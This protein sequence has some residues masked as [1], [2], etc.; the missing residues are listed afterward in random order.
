MAPSQFEIPDVP[1]QQE[2]LLAN[3]INSIKNKLDVAKQKKLEDENF[4]QLNNLVD[5]NSETLIILKSFGCKITVRALNLVEV[6]CAE[7]Q[8]KGFMHINDGNVEMD[9]NC[10]RIFKLISE[11]ISGGY[12]IDDILSKYETEEFYPYGEIE[13]VTV[14]YRGQEIKASRGTLMNPKGETRSIVFYRG[15]EITPDEQET[16]KEDE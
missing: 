8:L 6:D 13:Q 1:A 3:F 4:A 5:E 2:S 7:F 15:Y 14:T 9:E 10:Q 16:T 12:R 11:I